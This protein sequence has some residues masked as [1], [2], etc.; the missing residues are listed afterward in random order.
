MNWGGDEPVGITDCVRHIED[1]T[2]VPARLVPS[3][4][5]RETYQF[6]PALRRRLTGPCR[7]GWRDGIERTLR[8]LHP[9]HL[10]V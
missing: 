4:V 5:T 8:A 1:L 6:D 9:D 2:G 3:A 7:V 10:R